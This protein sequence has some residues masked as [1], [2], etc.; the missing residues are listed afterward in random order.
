M[1]DSV[2]QQAASRVCVVSRES[3][4]LPELIHLSICILVRSLLWDPE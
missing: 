1:Q 3:W 2:F 4:A